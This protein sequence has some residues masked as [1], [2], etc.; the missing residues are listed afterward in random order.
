MKKITLL[1]AFCALA[2]PTMAQKAKKKS[3][4]ASKTE[5]AQVTDAK[6]K[7]LEENNR[8]S[9]MHHYLQQW[10][11]HWRD[12]MKVWSGENPE[13][14][15]YLLEKEGRISCEGKLL[16]RNISGRISTGPYEAYE[17]VNYDN[18]KRKFVKTWF[19]NLGTNI[20]VLEGTLDE[21]TNTLT[22]EGATIDPFTMQTIKVRQVLHI[23]DPEN[24]LLE[25]FVQ[26]KDEKP[27]KTMEV[28]STRN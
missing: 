4:T 10:S 5:E 13:P 21:K 11:G 2:I 22:F 8:L 19:D 3:N 25:V 7:I 26:L 27:I 15:I 9:P 17:T 28:K 12:V 14:T 23:Q 1:F 24:Q 18:L 20:L 16:L 6:P